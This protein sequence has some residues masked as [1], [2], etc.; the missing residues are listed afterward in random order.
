M[1]K[2]DTSKAA[3]KMVQNKRGNG[4]LSEGETNPSLTL[5]TRETAGEID[6]VHGQLASVAAADPLLPRE[7]K[8]LKKCCLTKDMLR[9]TTGSGLSANDGS[10]FVLPQREHLPH[11]E[12]FWGRLGCSKGY[13]AWLL[14]HLSVHCH[15][16]LQGDYCSILLEE[17]GSHSDGSGTSRQMTSKVK[18]SGDFQLPSKFIY[19]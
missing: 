19:N 6:K 4:F 17:Q 13:G 9:S 1:A 2:N 5:C 11:G 8:H 14:Y 12:S 16:D 15:R 18:N 10:H 3:Q 7:E